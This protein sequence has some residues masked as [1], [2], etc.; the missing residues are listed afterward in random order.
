MIPE[1]SS[2]SQL[3]IGAGKSIPGKGK[4][5][6]LSLCEDRADFGPSKELK[7][8]WDRMQR[9]SMSFSSILFKPPFSPAT[10]VR[11]TMLL[12]VS[13]LCHSTILLKMESLSSLP[14]IARYL[15]QLLT[16]PEHISKW[17]IERILIIPIS[18]NMNSHL[19]GNEDKIPNS[20]F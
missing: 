9:E 8:W 3:G 13:L 5:Y 16:Y 10:M 19:P 1:L 4:A 20:T 18:V 2:A 15:P 12:F 17:V 7:S 14:S 6:E 11:L